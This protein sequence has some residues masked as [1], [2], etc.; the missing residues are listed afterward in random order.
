MVIAP[1]LSVTREAP[2]LYTYMYNLIQAIDTMILFQ[3]YNDK[4]IS[5]F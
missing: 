2:N 3:L 1:I 4:D 5:R